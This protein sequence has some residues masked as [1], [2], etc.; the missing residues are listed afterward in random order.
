LTCLA[1]KL[2][3]KTRTNKENKWIKRLKINS[4]N[5][6]NFLNSN[7]DSQVDFRD[8]FYYKDALTV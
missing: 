7:K 1:E 6:I 3:V 8:P 2:P 5:F 4:C